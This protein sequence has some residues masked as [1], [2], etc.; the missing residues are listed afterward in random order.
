M[1]VTPLIV[2]VNERRKLQALREVAFLH[3]VNI[4][5]VIERLKTPEGKKAHMDQMTRQS[6]LIPMAYMVT[7]SIETEH[8]AGTCRHMSMSVNKKGRVPNRHEVWMVAEVL[9]FW[10]SLEHCRVWPEKLQGHG[11]AINVVQPLERPIEH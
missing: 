6:V 3:P 4:R 11:V 2:G 10:G 1:T 5:Q 7:F 8:P 9:G